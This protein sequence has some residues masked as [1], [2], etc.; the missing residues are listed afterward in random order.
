MIEEVKEI[1]TAPR[2]PQRTQAES[3]QDFARFMGDVHEILRQRPRIAVEGF[4]I[5]GE[6]SRAL[7]VAVLRHDAFQHHQRRGAEFEA[8]AAKKG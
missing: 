7:D 8:V 6:T 2:L 3:G 5:G 4:L 1:G